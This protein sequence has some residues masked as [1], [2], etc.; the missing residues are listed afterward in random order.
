MQTLRHE[1][2]D[3]ILTTR[4]FKCLLCT[5]L[6]ESSSTRPH[7]TVACSCGHLSLDGGL[8]TGATINGDPRRMEDLSV[9]RTQDGLLLPQEVVTARYA[10]MCE[11]MYPKR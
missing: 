11:K 2:R 4:R 1:G 10:R 9:Y 8:T 3:Y 6:A 7:D 5:T